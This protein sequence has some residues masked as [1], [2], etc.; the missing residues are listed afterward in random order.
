MGGQLT[1]AHSS[2]GGGAANTAVSLQ[3]T[4][5][6]QA[7]LFPLAVVCSLCDLGQDLVNLVTFLVSFLGLRSLLLLSGASFNTAGGT[8]FLELFWSM[9]KTC[10]VRVIQSLAERSHV[11]QSSDHYIVTPKTGRRILADSQEQN[12]SL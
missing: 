6:P 3:L 2:M 9:C 11:N 5:R 4:A 10:Y 7:S 1:Q 8:Y 12:Q